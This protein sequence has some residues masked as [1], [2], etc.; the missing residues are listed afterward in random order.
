MSKAARLGKTLG[1]KWT[2]HWPCHWYCDDGKRS[3]TKF[4]AG[5][6][7]F[8]NPV[9]PGQYWLYGDGEPR[10]AEQY[11]TNKTHFSALP[12]AKP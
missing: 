2:Y 4:S 3:V 10:R 12:G 11:I 5:V 1:G 8:E 6:D 7:E 9:G